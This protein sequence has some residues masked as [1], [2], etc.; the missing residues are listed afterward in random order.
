MQQTSTFTDLSDSA[1]NMK[2]YMNTGIATKVYSLIDI[3]LKCCMNNAINTL[4]DNAKSKPNVF[5]VM[6]TIKCTVKPLRKGTDK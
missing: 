4:V 1:I 5:G 6:K 2:P 3:S